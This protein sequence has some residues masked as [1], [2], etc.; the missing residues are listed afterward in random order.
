MRVWG[1]ARLSGDQ[2]VAAPQG[3]VKTPINCLRH[4]AERI[5]LNT[6]RSSHGLVPRL[7]LASPFAHPSLPLLALNEST[8][9][10]WPNHLECCLNFGRIEMRRGY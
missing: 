3:A 1:N 9:F 7:S 2:T 8:A 10:T 6:L 5:F 4:P